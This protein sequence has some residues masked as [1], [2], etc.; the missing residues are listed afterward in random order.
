MSHFDRILG[1]KHGTAIPNPKGPPTYRFRGEGTSRNERAI[2]YEIPNKNKP[3]RPS[4]KRFTTSELDM[5]IDELKNK[6]V[7]S[8]T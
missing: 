5:V 6:R 4:T 1:I 7:V 3:D 2:V 8:A